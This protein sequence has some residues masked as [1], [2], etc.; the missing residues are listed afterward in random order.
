M[1][2]T[3]REHA[4]FVELALE[5]RL[6]GYWAQHI[7]ESIDEVIGH[8]HHRV[9][10]N[11]SGVSFLSSAGMRVLIQA[12]QQ[13]AAVG[14][15]LTVTEPGTGVLQVLE[16]AGLAMLLAQP[17]VAASPE[18]ALEV[19]SREIEGASFEFYP[20]AAGS[21]HCR[22]VGAP[23]GLTGSAVAANDSRVVDVCSSGLVL[24]IGAFGSS[25]DGCR[26]CLGEF[27]GVSGAV[28]CQPT[29]VTNFP[30]YMIA[31]GSY[32]PHVVTLSGLTCD[33]RFGPTIRFEGSSLPVSLS[34]VL[35]ACIPEAGDFGVVMVVESAGLIGAALKKSPASAVP[36]DGSMFQHP[37]VR[38]WLSF[39][40][41]RAY[42]RS[43]A[44]IAG[45]ASRSPGP[46]LASWLR[47]IAQTIPMHA[48]LHAAAFGYRPLQKG[49]IE[50][51]AAV[52]GLFETGGLQGVMHLLTDDREITGGGESEFRR[53]ACWVAPILQFAAQE[54]AQ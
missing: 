12:Y 23:G 39:S 18:I 6:D 43:L 17:S 3:R 42:P 38:R 9:R 48:H 13:L 49:N 10:L 40:P 24:G 34:R 31:S 16:M 33:G 2:I 50:I 27:I 1:E 11:F 14:G 46:Q 19:I 35:D 26:D 47:P 21:L 30:D 44:V 41:Q 54:H 28:A 32:I 22:A 45:V 20:G 5:G 7:A 51:N 36:E 4:G 52:R 29:D 25:F 15:W 53:G 8:G 37:E